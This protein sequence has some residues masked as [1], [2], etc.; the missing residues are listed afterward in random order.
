MNCAVF[1][2]SGWCVCVGIRGQC[3]PLPAFLKHRARR[4]K[5]K[6]RF[7]D[8]TTCSQGGVGMSSKYRENRGT[9]TDLEWWYCL[10]SES[11]FTRSNVQKNAARTEGQ[12]NGA[13]N[14]ARCLY[15]VTFAGTYSQDLKAGGI[16]R[17]REN[18]V[19]DAF[20]YVCISGALIFFSTTLVMT[21]LSI[22]LS[23]FVE[24]PTI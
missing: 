10:A 6:A 22:A 7:R 16:S 13:P 18:N 4:E 14:T 5:K 11:K 15:T 12:N 23:R 2:F 17:V 9:K 20:S 8:V 3:L 19:Q 21:N 1:F 24:Q